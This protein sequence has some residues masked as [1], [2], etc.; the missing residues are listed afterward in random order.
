SVVVARYRC[1]VADDDYSIVWRSALSEKDESA[2]LLVAK[3]Y[4][5]KAFLLKIELKQGGLSVIKLAHCPQ[6]SLDALVQRL[7]AKMPVQ[8]R[9]VIPL[10]PLPQPSS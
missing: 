7:L 1:E 10:S 6:A 4:P 9:I 5:F 8:T 2:V 3:I